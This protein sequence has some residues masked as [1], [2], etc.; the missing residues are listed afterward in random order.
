MPE[1]FPSEVE[2]VVEE[3]NALLD[4]NTAL[5]VRAR[6]HA[7]DLAHG[8]KHPLMVLAHEAR[9]V[10]GEH[11]RVIAEQVTTMRSA[12]E[13]NLAR[14][15]V[16]GP[17]GAAGMCAS[18]AEA[19]EALRYSLD[20][21]YQDRGLRI[22]AEGL[23]SLSFAGDAQDLEEML[24]NLMENACKWGRSRIRVAAS[25]RNGRLAIA[26]EDDGKGVAKEEREVVLARGGRLDERVAGAGLGL[27]IVCDIAEIYNGSL[28]LAD[29]DLGGL[30]V[31][32]SLPASE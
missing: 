18:V 30:K 14:A 28:R 5:L 1:T 9:E 20:L 3:L 16:A 26:V 11:G 21:L 32:L 29:S 23:D 4:H 12:V 27:G 6:T 13:R 31:E 7:G 15:R 22:E 2:P 19:F 24:G 25:R 17:D 8:L 10:G